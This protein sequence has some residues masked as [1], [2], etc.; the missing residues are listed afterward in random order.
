MIESL[1]SIFKQQADLRGTLEQEH[2]FIRGS[3]F[4][5]ACTPCRAEE[6]DQVS[7][8]FLGVTPTPVIYTEQVA[9]GNGLWDI[10]VS[11]GVFVEGE[12]YR[13]HRKALGFHRF[14]FKVRGVFEL[15]AVEVND[16]LSGIL[17]GHC[18]T[19][20]TRG[21]TF[22]RG[23]VLGVNDL[24]CMVMSH[25][26]GAI[27][28]AQVCKEVDD[29]TDLKIRILRLSEEGRDG[30]D[31]NELGLNFFYSGFNLLCENEIE[32]SLFNKG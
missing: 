10:V 30:F 23:I 9:L 18:P 12:C 15:F 2:N 13:R 8:G 25:D 24:T 29:E 27:F 3:T 5:P 17:E 20:L 11:E 6:V 4:A 14:D 26:C 19:C 16:T 28:L 21:D 7:N 32:L 22:L 1:P 31:D